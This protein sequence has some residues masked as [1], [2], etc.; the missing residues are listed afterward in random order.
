MSNSPFLNPQGL[1]GPADGLLPSESANSQ[2]PMLHLTPAATTDWD[3]K[4]GNRSQ[5]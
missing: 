5:L 2:V 1:L 4:A 3:N